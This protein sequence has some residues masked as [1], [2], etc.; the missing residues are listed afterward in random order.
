M[1]KPAILVVD[2]DAE[3]LRALARDVR[4]KYG[5]DYRVL[6]AESG[7]AA[8]EVLT[9]ID[10]RGEPVALVLTDQRMPQ[11]DGVTLLSRARDAPFSG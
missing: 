8:L 7:A 9:E 5:P 4:Q 10:R 6:R 3:V 2:D 11:L 1:E